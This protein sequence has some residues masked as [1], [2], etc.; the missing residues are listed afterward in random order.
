MNAEQ[1]AKIFGCT[2]EQAKAQYKAN[3][4][5]LRKMQSKANGK[6]V[7][8]YTAKQLSTMAQKIEAL[9]K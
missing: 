1:V 8:G 6:K 3:A 4:E 7:N 9:A 5:Q 2:V